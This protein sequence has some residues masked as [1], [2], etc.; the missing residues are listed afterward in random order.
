MGPSLIH[1]SYA[2]AY[3]SERH[4]ARRYRHTPRRQHDR[5]RPAAG[6]RITG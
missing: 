4:D 3:H 2:A 1:L 6:D 5:S